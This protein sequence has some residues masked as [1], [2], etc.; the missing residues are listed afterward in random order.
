MAQLTSILGTDTISSS[1]GVI[2]NNFQSLN[3]QS[4][5]IYK[6]SVQTTVSS[7]LVNDSELLVP[8]QA[9]ETLG[10]VLKLVGESGITPDFKYTFNAP[11]GTVGY[12]AD[13]D[14]FSSATSVGGIRTISGPGP[15]TPFIGGI[16]GVFINNSV[17]G[18]IQFQW[19]QNVNTVS[20]VTSV[21][22]GSNIIVTKLN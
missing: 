18:T 21:F 19:A 20:S 14:A 8:I 13:D 1:R 6:S 16:N 9:N 7:V 12:F 22:K 4:Q 5:V 3:A 11:I 17:A 2:N 10:V 15:N